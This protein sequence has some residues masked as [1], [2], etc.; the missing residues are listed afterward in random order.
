MV[1]PKLLDLELENTHYSITPPNPSAIPLQDPACLLPMAKR[2]QTQLKTGIQTWM[3]AI[4]S[5]IHSIPLLE[6]K[7]GHD[8]GS[9]SMCGD[10]T[11]SQSWQRLFSLPCAYPCPSPGI[12]IGIW[13]GK[14]CPKLLWLGYSHLPPQDPSCSCA[15]S[16]FRKEHS[17]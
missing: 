10:T 13:A 12:P 1:L 5:P 16:I 4:P 3:G 14:S 9:N 11:P 2:L 8:S 15:P 17:L 7:Q 6:L